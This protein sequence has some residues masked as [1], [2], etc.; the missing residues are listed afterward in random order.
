MN[1]TK[2]N[3]FDLQILIRVAILVAMDV[4]LMNYL[5]IHTQFFKIGFAFVPIALCGMLYGPKWGAACA[6][7]GDLINCLL[8]PFCWYPPLTLSACLNG[9]VFGLFLKGRSDHLGAIVAAV[10][11]FQIGISLLLTTWFLSMLYT[12]PFLELMITRIPQVLVMFPV[13]VLV[14]RL[15]GSKKLVTALA[16]SAA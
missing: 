11:V 14:L 4:L 6:G 15:I 2:K 1:Q 12:T 9:F 5:G 16:G 10:S 13:Q 7:V 8:G 3:P